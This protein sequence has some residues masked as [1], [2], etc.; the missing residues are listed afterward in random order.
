[1]TKDNLITNSLVKQ[2]KLPS[3]YLENVPQM[4]NN[5]PKAMK[6]LGRKKEGINNWSYQ[7][8]PL[9]MSEDKTIDFR[10]QKGTLNKQ[11][12]AIR[13]YGDKGYTPVGKNVSKSTE[14]NRITN[15][16]VDE[17]KLP[18]WQRENKP[19]R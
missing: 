2:G 3:K 11:K 8:N 12:N 5:K 6:A 16:L 13:Q 10:K 7:T 17:G 1:M 4:R 18:E 15:K 9:L 19:Q 14:D